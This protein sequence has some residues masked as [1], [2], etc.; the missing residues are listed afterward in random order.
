[1]VRRLADSEFVSLGGWRGLFS[2][3]D[4]IQAISEGI[5]GDIRSFI[6]NFWPDHFIGLLKRMCR[7]PAIRGFGFMRS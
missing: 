6:L 4:K 3:D 5:S 7:Y 1:M 2:V